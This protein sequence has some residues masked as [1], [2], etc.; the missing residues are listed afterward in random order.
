[1]RK[2]EKYLRN[3]YNSTYYND[4]EFFCLSDVEDV[5]EAY[6]QSRV[7]AISDEEIDMGVDNWHSFKKR[8]AF[9]E[10]YNYL[11]GKLLKQ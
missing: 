3:H 1:M 8:R 10:G 9:L 5:M 2:A 7:N 4:E 6:H 11:K